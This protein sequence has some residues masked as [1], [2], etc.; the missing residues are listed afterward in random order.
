MRQF[1]CVTRLH[2]LEQ[3]LKQ[4]LLYFDEIKIQ[5]LFK[6]LSKDAYENIYD[7]IV[8]LLDNGI[9]SELRPLNELP[10]DK[11]V[12][13]EAQEII[14]F[15]ESKVKSVSRI[16]HKI[17]N[18]LGLL[19]SSGM[20][21]HSQE[22]QKA[23][24]NVDSKLGTIIS[25]LEI[26]MKSE[27]IQLRIGALG[28]E[29]GNSNLTAIPY[30]RYSPAEFPIGPNRVHEVLSVIHRALPAL[31]ENTP[32]EA[33][34]DFRTDSES[35]AKFMTLRNWQ[36]E[37][38]HSKFSP[39]ELSEKLEYLIDD[40]QNYMK[41]QKIKYH[42]DLLE[43]LIVESLEVIENLLRLKWGKAARKLFTLRKKK[44]SLLEAE[45]KAPGREVSYI[46]KA[47]ETFSRNH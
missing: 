33:I 37:A 40:Y 6:H 34:L 10:L 26:I 47:R 35:K 29:Q 39:N 45:I 23:L 9:V 25:D 7:D 46:V 1:I 30:Y 31:D 27:C 8:Y 42:N 11:T 19:R 18:E 13:S 12:L 14:S 3:N 21:I 38:V 17:R 36:I 15:E 4:A 28:L 41:L 16:S 43:T 2:S 44:I 20:E 22:L 5:N 24:Q 32:L